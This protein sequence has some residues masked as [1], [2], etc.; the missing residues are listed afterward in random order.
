MTTG[1]TVALAAVL[2]AAG[3]GA[4]AAPVVHGQSTAPRAVR[5]VPRDVQIISGRGSEIGV[6][7][8]DVDEADAKGVKPGATSGV[9]IEDVSV[10]S[11]AE[12]AGIKSGDVIVEFDGERVRS[13]RQFAR[14]V[15]ET[16]AGR[17]VSTSL[18]RAGQKT[19][20]TVEPRASSGFR[21]LEGFGDLDVLRKDFS[22]AV[23]PAPAGTARCR[24]P[25][26][27]RSG[28]EPFIWRSG[29]ALGITVGDLSPQLA[30]YFG[31]KDGV[32]VT[33]VRE[34]SA[35][36]KGRTESRRRDHVAQRDHRRHTGGAP[37]ADSAARGRARSSRSAIVRDK[38]AL[39]IKGKVDPSPDRRRTV[40]F[41][42]LGR[43]TAIRRRLRLQCERRR[44]HERR[45]LGGDDRRPPRASRRP[46]R[47]RAGLPPPS[48][49]PLPRA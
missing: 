21:Y 1:K 4:P 35:A 41:D 6:S 12:K 13:A 15:Q 30:D 45:E 22:F 18:L 46:A 49:R 48:R 3:L 10:G 25:H 37:P 17:K 8:R 20:V 9:I 26:P 44:S 40:R 5:A 38:K 34:D 33:A 27:C 42:C 19:T 23:P 11:P 16:P 43:L 36:G 47:R 28:F 24:R 7:I 29:S 2:V 39:T 32:L 14:L 31:T